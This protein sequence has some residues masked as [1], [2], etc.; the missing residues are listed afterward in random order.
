VP[1]PWYKDPA[2]IVT[3]AGIGAAFLLLG[4][5]K[6]IVDV[7]RDVFARG[8][9]V[10]YGTLDGPLGIVIESPEALRYAASQR[11]GFDIPQD[12]YALA[13]MIRSEGAAQGLL[14]AHVAMN[15]LISF[16]YANTLFE[17]LTFSND[18]KRRGVYGV[19]YSGPVPPDYP[20]ANARRYS[21]SANPYEGDVQTAIHAI[22]E[23]NQGIDRA[24]GA[25]KFIDRDSMGAQIGSR[26]FEVVN[27]SWVADGMEPFTLPEYGDNLV[28]YRKA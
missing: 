26:S 28:L 6:A 9:H 15:D 11:M 4:G 19:Q 13:R 8:S 3:G 27:A 20:N 17:L 23:R 16:P 10:S 24:S 2:V 18:T 5:G 21:T 25:T 14:R 1:G 7:T 22:D 12:A